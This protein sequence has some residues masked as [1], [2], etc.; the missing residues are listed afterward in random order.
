MVIGGLQKFSLAD[1]PGKIAAIVFSR[2]CNFRCPYCHNPE[3][4]VTEQY[5]TPILQEEVFEFLLTRR[6]Q[7]QGVVVTGGEPTQQEDLPDFLAATRELGFSTKLDTNG[8]NP[9]MLGKVLALGLVDYLAMDIK[10]PLD[11]YSRV[12]G[13]HVDTKDIEKSVRLVMECGVAHEFRTTYLE[14]LLSTDEMK[15]I[16]EL[17]RGCRLFVLQ[18]FRSAR[19]L[20][21][22]MR[23]Q[24][25]PDG[26]RL[27]E[28]Q[29]IMEST[30]MRVLVR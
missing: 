17:V 6:G 2:G 28:I 21:P 8:S 24:P 9:R 4:V 14:S 12:T 3:L 19:T 27:R 30:C 7:L 16:A 13:V 20:D 18:S 5:A 26:K 29:E 1:F 11:S 10:A 15:G 23:G 25:M 22:G